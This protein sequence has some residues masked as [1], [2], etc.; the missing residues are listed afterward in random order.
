MFSELEATRSPNPIFTALLQEQVAE[1]EPR[2][3]FG[4]L[5][6]GGRLATLVQAD[7]VHDPEPNLVLEPFPHRASLA[8]GGP[9]A[10][11]E[12][13]PVTDNGHPVFR[14]FVSVT[15]TGSI[16]LNLR[17]VVEQGE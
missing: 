14:T 12:V 7:V 11:T 3:V 6:A 17:K 9:V 16:N 4:T 1:T 13:I 5:P 10:A 8:A 15:P 2:L